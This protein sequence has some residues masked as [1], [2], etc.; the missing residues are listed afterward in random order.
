[1][2]SGYVRDHEIE[3][4]IGPANDRTIPVML[5]RLPLDGTMNLRGFEAHQIVRARDGRAYNEL[6][7]EDERDAFALR[8]ALGIQG[9]VKAELERGTLT[10]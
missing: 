6:V 8:L 2:A 7:R 4:F 9:R 3:P 10:P 5:K 1:L